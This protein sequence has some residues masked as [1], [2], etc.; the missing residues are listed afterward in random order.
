MATSAPEPC[1]WTVL[2]C[3]QVKDKKLLDKLFVK[4]DSVV[5][6]VMGKEEQRRE[7]DMYCVSSII[8]SAVC[9]FVNEAF[10]RAKNRFI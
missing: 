1:G 9:I 8:V 6:T 2:G 4:S 10:R 7:M 5:R 3:A